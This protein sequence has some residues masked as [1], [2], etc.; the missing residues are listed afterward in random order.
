MAE[1]GGKLGPVLWQLPSAKAFDEDDLA[2]FLA[3]LPKAIAS[4]PV[5]H[6]LEVRHDSFRTPR[7]PALLRRFGVAVVC[8][9]SPKYPNIADLTADFVYARL[10]RAV[11]AEPCG[12]A[13]AELDA[14]ATRLCTW[15]GGG[16]P[17]DLPRLEAAEA[18]ATS[19]ADRAVLRLHDRRRQG[20]RPGGGDGPD[21]APRRFPLTTRWLSSP[22]RQSR[23]RERSEAIHAGNL[24]IHWIASPATRVRNDR[25]V[26]RSSVAA[27]LE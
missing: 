6:V 17:H 9:D 8:T 16:E 2:G 5:R 14:W 24:P 20:A 27:G 4:G 3:L 21:R 18:G 11:A 13:P 25:L 15:A 10:Q 22:S 26:T 12:Y 1:L 7:L 19:P 23:H